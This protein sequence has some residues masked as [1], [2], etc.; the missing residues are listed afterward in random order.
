MVFDKIKQSPG[1]WPFRCNRL[2]PCGNILQ[3]SC[4]CE[5]EANGHGRELIVY[6]FDEIGKPGKF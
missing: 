1:V 5:E 4:G 6:H 2:I 3:Q